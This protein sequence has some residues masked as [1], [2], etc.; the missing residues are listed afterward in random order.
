MFQIRSVSEKYLQCVN[1]NVL[2]RCKECVS[3]NRDR[4]LHTL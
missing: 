3:I 1:V 4:F 2:L